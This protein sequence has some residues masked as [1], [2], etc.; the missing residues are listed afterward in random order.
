M[1]EMIGLTRTVGGR[2]I[3]DEVSLQAEQGSL[4]AVLGPSG[5]G[6]T[7]LLRLIAGLDRP[8]AGEIRI[9]GRTVSSPERMTPPV[10][11]R[12]SL[13]FQHLALWP[14]LT[15]HGNIEFVIDRS[16]YPGKAQLREKI[17]RLLAMMHL[18]GHANRYPGELSGGERQRLAIARALGSDP[19]VLL[20]DEPF[21]NLDDLLKEEL[22]AMTRGLKDN[23]RMTI[24]YV[25]HN[26][27]EALFLADRIA[28]LK[29]G[30]V[31]RVWGNEEIKSLSRD[32]VL[33]QAFKTE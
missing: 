16:R 4:L 33:R 22:L 17:D 2:R 20:M 32:Q 21:S 12:V 15:A 3:L 1:I 18:S 28:V 26:I 6:K 31:T 7:S 25:T 13:I 29:E 24:V 14:H 30:R 19:E 9:S 23:G 27:D 5:S 10:L 11:R 8:S